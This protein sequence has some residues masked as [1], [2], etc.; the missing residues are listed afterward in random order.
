[1]DHGQYITPRFHIRRRHRGLQLD[2]FEYQRRWAVPPVLNVG[3]KEDP[4]G[5]RWMPGTVNVDLHDYDEQ[6]GEKLKLPNLVL[7]SAVNL[8]FKDQSFRTVVAAELIEHIQED[9]IST[10][11][12]EFSRVARDRIIVTTPRDERIG[13]SFADPFHKTLVTEEKI[14]NWIREMGWRAE[15]WN[16]GMLYHLEPIGPAFGYWFTLAPKDNGRPESH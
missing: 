3:C 13:S 6:K 5:L 11:F 12:A 4:A 14:R 1:V 8:P 16:A 2:R 15:D 7:A 9:G 10:A